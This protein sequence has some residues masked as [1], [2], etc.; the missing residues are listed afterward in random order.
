MSPKEIIKAARRD[1]RARSSLCSGA[2]VCN[3]HSCAQQ[4][5]ETLG[6][7]AVQGG[8]FFLSLTSASQL[9]F[10]SLNPFILK[11]FKAQKTAKRI[12]RAHTPLA[13]SPRDDVLHNRSVSSKSG[14][15]ASEILLTEDRPYSDP[16]RFYMLCA[17]ARARVIP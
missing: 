17:C 3:Q 7:L 1:L 6:S 4:G 14:H 10:F 12:Q 8:E 9:L 16:T 5:L 13:L 11:S 15:R 2:Q